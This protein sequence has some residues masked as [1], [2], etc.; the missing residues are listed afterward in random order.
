MVCQS[1]VEDGRGDMYVHNRCDAMRCEVMCCDV[2]RCDG[3]HADGCIHAWRLGMM[4]HGFACRCEDGLM[5]AWM[6]AD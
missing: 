2:M 5:D 1:G 6:D 4:L 3:T